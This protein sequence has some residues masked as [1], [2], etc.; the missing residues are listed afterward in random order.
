M[1]RGP[2]KRVG[3]IAEWIAESGMPPPISAWRL[4]RWLGLRLVPMLKLPEPVMLE[5]ETLRYDLE[6]M[7][8]QRHVLRECCR[9]VLESH[10]RSADTATVG[11]LAARLSACGPLPV[12]IVR[13]EARPGVAPTRPAHSADP[14]VAAAQ[15]VRRGRPLMLAPRQP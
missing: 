11:A 8:A 13:E 2:S 14:L 4:A 7:D 3:D 10:G 6:R 12:R 1:K 9:I 5:G 15:P